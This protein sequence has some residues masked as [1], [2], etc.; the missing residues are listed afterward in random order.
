[1]PRGI[2]SAAIVRACIVG[3]SGAL[4]LTLSAH[5]T[6]SAPAR[7]GRLYVVDPQGSDVRGDGSRHHPWRTLT[8]ACRSVAGGVGH[9][10]RVNPGTYT[11][12][13]SCT[14]PCK[15]SLRGSGRK[16]TTIKGSA[17]PLVRVANCRHRGNRQTISGLHLD[18]QQKTAGTRGMVA[19]N[20]YGLTIRD[21]LSENFKGSSSSGGA[22]HLKTVR[23]CEVEDS[24]FRNGSMIFSN[25][26][27]GAFGIEDAVDCVFHDLRLF[28]DQ[29]MAFKGWGGPLTNV[30]FYNIRAISGSPRLVTPEVTWPAISFELHEVD[31]VNV[32][33]RNSYFNATLSL[34]DKGASS[35]L[36]SG[37]RYRIHHNHFD[38]A[39]RAETGE[40]QYA[41]ELDQ[42]SS[43]VDHNYFD[44]GVHPIANFTAEPKRGNSVHHNVFDNQENWVALMRYRSGLFDF[45][46]YKN[47]VVMRQRWFDALFKVDELTSSSS[48]GIR[49]NIFWSAHPLGD[50]L[51]LGLDASSIVRNSFHNLEA[52]GKNPSVDDPRLRLTGGFPQA[53]VPAQRGPA[54]TL[55]A[56]AQGA[57]SVGPVRAR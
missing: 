28:D 50:R 33:I 40:V 51:G 16:A 41:L 57:W 32:T 54:V 44:G 3:L 8:K 42:N 53:Y 45:N 38:I 29:A 11:E 49:D 17:D 37:F 39:S 4:L 25:W 7:L 56:F 15:T 26:A 20:V 23:N 48:P 34:V 14:V 55:G 9:T 18:G 43:E 19:E 2:A 31:A 1:V 27:S 24:T 10:I 12:S 6:E 13:R 22:L 46:F 52:R 30:A 35:T 5:A 21:V 36:A 47:T